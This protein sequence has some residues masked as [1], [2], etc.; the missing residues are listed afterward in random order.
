M[1]LEGATSHVRT[2]YIQQ[3]PSFLKW[4]EI[5]LLAEMVEA[6]TKAKKEVQRKEEG[7]MALRAGG[8][9][10]LSF[11][12]PETE[13]PEQSHVS[14]D[15]SWTSIECVRLRTWSKT[16]QRH[17]KPGQYA[18][19]GHHLSTRFLAALFS[20]DDSLQVILFFLCVV[21]VR[22]GSGHGS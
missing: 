20:S 16:F 5:R 3:Q 13:D 11:S 2:A 19:L 1:M 9:R 7:Q 4:K 18:G 22:C 8:V 6:K 21:E 15:D 12:L 17:K 14:L 10:A